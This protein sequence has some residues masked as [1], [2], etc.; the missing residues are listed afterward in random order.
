[1]R[2]GSALLD[3]S[4]DW[5]VPA[6]PACDAFVSRL[7]AWCVSWIVRLFGFRLVEPTTSP[8]G[9]KRWN[10]RFWAVGPSDRG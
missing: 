3:A 2:H 8:T 5:E 9:C 1:M 6:E 10:H 4:Q 7:K